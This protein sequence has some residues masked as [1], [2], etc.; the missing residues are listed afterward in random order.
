MY[1]EMTDRGAPRQDPA[2]YNGDQICPFHRNF[3]MLRE[4]SFPRMRADTRFGM[5]TRIEICTVGGYSTS[6]CT[7]SFMTLNSVRVV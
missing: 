2:K 5:F 7:C 4:N 1:S 6:R 3:E